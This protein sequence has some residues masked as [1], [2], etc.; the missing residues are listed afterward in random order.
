MTHQAD[1]ALQSGAVGNVLIISALP[2]LHCF[3]V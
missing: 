3:H 2:F 1:N